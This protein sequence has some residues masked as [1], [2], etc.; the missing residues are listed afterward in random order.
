MINS[1]AYQATMARATLPTSTTGPRTLQLSAG[2]RAGFA[3]SENAGATISQPIFGKNRHHHYQRHRDHD[4]AP[5]VSCRS[6]LKEAAALPARSGSW[7]PGRNCAALSPA[8]WSRG[9]PRRTCYL[10]P[11]SC[12]LRPWSRVRPRP[13]PNTQGSVAAPPAEGVVFERGSRHH[14]RAAT[15]VTAYWSLAHVSLLRL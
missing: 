2:Q 10:R 15:A 8:C 5:I 14:S 1:T 13:K 3:L 6:I 7:A 9:P 12:S 11:N 4:C